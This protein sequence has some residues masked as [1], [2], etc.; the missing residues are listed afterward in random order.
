VEAARAGEHGKGFAVVAAEVRKLAERSKLAADEIVELTENSL[1]LSEM[2]GS[3]LSEVLPEIKKTS[4]LLQEITA[5]SIEQNNGA[6]QVNNAVQ[7]LNTVIQQNASVSEEMASSAKELESQAQ[8]LELLVSFFKL[9]NSKTFKT[10]KSINTP[11]QREQAQIIESQK[12]KT[13]ANPIKPPKIELD[14][15]EE[16]FESF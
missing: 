14:I 15:S 13:P 2:A 10:R 3:K 12:L 8:S 7:Q 9:N 1:Q 5:A 11:G 16:D 6:S 4:E